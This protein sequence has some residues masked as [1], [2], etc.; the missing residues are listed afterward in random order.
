[1]SNVT[2]AIREVPRTLEAARLL[3][4]VFSGLM[5]LPTMPAWSLEA[6][7]DRMEARR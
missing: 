2:G 7:I 3:E 6:F 4:E 1:M 5:E